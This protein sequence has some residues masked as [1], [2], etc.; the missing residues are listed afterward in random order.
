MDPLTLKVYIWMFF[1]TVIRDQNITFPDVSRTFSD[2]V[3]GTLNLT[4]ILGTGLETITNSVQNMEATEDEDGNNNLCVLFPAEHLELT[5]NYD[6][7]IGIDDELPIYG[8]GYLLFRLENIAFNACMFINHDENYI[9][10]VV[11]N[12]LYRHTPLE[13]TGFWRNNEV[14]IILTRLLNIA[15]RYIAMWN[16][17][18]PERTSCLWSPLFSYALNVWFENKNASLDFDPLCVKEIISDVEEGNSGA[19]IEE[20]ILRKM[21]NAQKSDGNNEF[22]ELIENDKPIILPIIKY[23]RQFGMRYI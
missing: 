17:Y 8:N 6:A 11:V 16:N 9:D 22:H 5:L 18:E 19:E 14:S 23:L 2:D 3:L 1:N 10:D 13:L 7:D 20:E 21:L 15:N 12:L 4:N